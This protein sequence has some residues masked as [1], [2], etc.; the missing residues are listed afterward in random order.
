LYFNYEGKNIEDYK[1]KIYEVLKISAD[2]SINLDTI[3]YLIDKKLP[4]IHPKRIKKIDV[5]PLHTIFAKDENIYT[6]TLLTEIAKK[7]LPLEAFSLS[8]SIEEAFSEGSFKE[9]S[10]FNKQELQIW[11]VDATKNYVFAP[12]KVTQLFYDRIPEVLNL[13][14]KPPFDVEILKTNFNPKF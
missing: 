1:E 3:G 2:R 7:T 6:H 8:L 13:L 9:G 10:F 14:S 11:K 4:K 5:G 12:H